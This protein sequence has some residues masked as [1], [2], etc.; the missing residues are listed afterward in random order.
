MGSG[1]LLGLLGALIYVVIT[2]LPDSSTQMLSWTWVII[3]QAGLVSIA[4]ISILNLWQREKPFFLLGNNLDWAIALIALIVVQ[5][6]RIYLIQQFN[7]QK[8]AL[9]AETSRYINDLVVREYMN[10]FNG[11]WV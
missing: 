1:K 10:E 6:N 11:V 4:S 3:W 2:L 5:I 9:N 8:I 7:L